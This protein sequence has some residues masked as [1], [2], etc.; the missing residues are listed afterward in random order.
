[1]N[2]LT[3]D[4]ALKKKILDKMS[5]ESTT[6]QSTKRP[7]LRFVGAMVCMLAIVFAVASWLFITSDV[8]LPPDGLPMCESHN[9]LR[10]PSEAMYAIDVLDDVDSHGSAIFFPS[11]S[12]PS[13]ITGNIPPPYNIAPD[14]VPPPYL[15][16]IEAFSQSRVVLKNP[17]L[18]TVDSRVNNLEPNRITVIFLCNEQEAFE[19]LVNLSV[20]A[21]GSFTVP[22]KGVE[23]WRDSH[24]N[25]WLPGTLVRWT[26][27]TS[28]TITLTAVLSNNE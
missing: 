8:G 27:E 1:M 10:H 3:A 16:D 7:V 22:S 28:G 13:A 12:S 21:P 6:H 17:P 19:G 5:L 15:F 20:T 24:G 26:V 18:D 11:L 4:P 2:S 23:G 25:I 14:I 9:L